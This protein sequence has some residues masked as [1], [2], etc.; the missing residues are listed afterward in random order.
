MTGWLGYKESQMK[1]LCENAMD[2]GFTAFKIKV[3]QN[4]EDDKKRCRIIR[5]TIGSDKVL[6]RY[7]C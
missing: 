1:K 2:Q 4:L 6:V 3:G 5:E 7:Q